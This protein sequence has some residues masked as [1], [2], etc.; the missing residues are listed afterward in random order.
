[1]KTIEVLRELEKMIA[2][3]L[4]FNDQSAIFELDQEIIDLVNDSFAKRI[5]S[6]AKELDAKNSK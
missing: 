6:K 1:M 2:N 3:A 4:R 5:S